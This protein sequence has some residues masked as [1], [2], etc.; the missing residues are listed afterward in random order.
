MWAGRHDSQCSRV[1]WT[2]RS[3]LINGAAVFTV[4][5]RPTSDKQGLKTPGLSMLLGTACL[6]QSG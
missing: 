4:D 6:R 3:T 1:L 2:L 5:L